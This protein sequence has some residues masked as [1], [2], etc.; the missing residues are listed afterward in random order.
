MAKITEAAMTHAP[1]P[2]CWNTSMIFHQKVRQAPRLGEEG[3]LRDGV[4]QGNH[5]LWL[6]VESVGT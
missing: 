4:T 2:S 1:S 6:E 3:P 5:F